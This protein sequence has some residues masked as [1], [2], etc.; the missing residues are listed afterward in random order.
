MTALIAANR[1][2]YETYASNLSVA[3]RKLLLA[4]ATEP[5]GRF[6]EAYRIKYNLG[7]SS[8]VNTAINR[9]MESG[10]VEQ[11][12]GRYGLGDPIFRHYL[13]GN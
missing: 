9:L 3:Q 1:D 11:T 4:L 7:V 6:T 13:M 5:T 8:T 10:L 12:D 2:L